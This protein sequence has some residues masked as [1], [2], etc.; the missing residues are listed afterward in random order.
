M[1][2]PAT[3]S[4]REQALKAAY[5]QLG[6][7]QG[8]KT[9]DQS[10]L[11]EYNQGIKAKLKQNVNFGLNDEGGEDQANPP[12]I[13]EYPLWKV[14]KKIERD[15]PSDT[16]EQ[17]KKKII[18]IGS[19]RAL[20]YLRIN[21][22]Y[23][24]ELAFLYDVDK[25][26]FHKFK[27]DDW[28]KTS[29]HD[30]NDHGGWRGQEYQPLNDIKMN[31][32]LTNH[33][34]FYVRS[35]NDKTTT[36]PPWTK[37]E[38]QE[39]L[40]TE[41]ANIEIIVSA[42]INEEYSEQKQSKF[43]TLFLNNIKPYGTGCASERLQDAIVAIG[44][45]MQG[46]HSFNELLHHSEACKK[47]ITLIQS[48]DK[49]DLSKMAEVHL[50]LF[51]ELQRQTIVFANGTEINVSPEK[52]IDI[53]NKIKAEFIE[54]NVFTA[55]SAPA[56]YKDPA[57]S[58]INAIELPEFSGEGYI[59][60]LKFET[61]LEAEKAFLYS[62]NLIGKDY[63]EFAKSKVIQSSPGNGFEFSISQEQYM[64]LTSLKDA[65]KPKLEKTEEEQIKDIII[66]K[67]QQIR[68]K[69]QLTEGEYYNNIFFSDKQKISVSNIGFFSL[70]DQEGNALD[71]RGLQNEEEEEI[72]TLS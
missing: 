60:K 56:F 25:S 67:L 7:D 39:R 22:E 42:M 2:L 45:E 35:F 14:M 47:L 1:T 57:A 16:E 4:D 30:L 17:R 6:Y 3:D 21:R 72:N 50:D 23:A 48:Q 37:E 31:P 8:K 44:T 71:E 9:Y 10:K 53:V 46:N 62:Q 19:I 43:L 33:L 34:D 59:G 69:L 18:A 52:Y 24:A 61:S 27:L 66:A 29:N 41:L 5:K 55:S 64:T 36:T 11:A 32:R 70:T 40:D 26:I 20:I 58:F 49:N 68:D 63:P 13:K 38:I 28:N 51:V 15:A 54:S 12:G 65:A